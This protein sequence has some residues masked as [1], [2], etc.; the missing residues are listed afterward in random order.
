VVLVRPEP[1]SIATS[2]PAVIGAQAAR[3]AEL[4]AEL[5]AL[6]GDATGGG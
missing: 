5:A 3:I 1:W 4:E 6:R 2:D